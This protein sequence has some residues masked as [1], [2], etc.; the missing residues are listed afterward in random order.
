GACR[1]GPPARLLAWAPAASAGA[2]RQ[3]Y[4]IP[5]RFAEVGA[6]ASPSFRFLP[7]SLEILK[8]VQVVE[9]VEVFPFAALAPTLAAALRNHAARLLV[10]YELAAA[11]LGTATNGLF[12]L[13]LVLEVVVLDVKRQ[14]INLRCR[15]FDLF[16]SFGFGPGLGFSAGGFSTSRLG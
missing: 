13:F 8:L 11:L 15:F 1:T 16:L 4:G 7:V 3:S 2:W 10:K 5:R 9:S 6:C 12:V 14:F